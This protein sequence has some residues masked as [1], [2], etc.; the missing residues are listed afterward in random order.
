MHGGESVLGADG[1]KAQIHGYNS[2]WLYSVFCNAV[3]VT[4]THLF[5]AVN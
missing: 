3:T 1:G 5:H 2:P 4:I